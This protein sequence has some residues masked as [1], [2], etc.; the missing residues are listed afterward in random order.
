[1]RAFV[2]L[3]DSVL[4]DKSRVDFLEEMRVYRGA[5]MGYYME[6]YARERLFLREVVGE[7]EAIKAGVTLTAVA[8]LAGL[9]VPLHPICPSHFNCVIKAPL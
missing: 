9:A 4:A 1:M 8:P 6:L 3:A 5:K 2:S 7:L